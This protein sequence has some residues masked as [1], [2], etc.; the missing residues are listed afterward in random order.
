[1]EK[2]ASTSSLIK[3]VEVKDRKGCGPFSLSPFLPPHVNVYFA[4]AADPWSG[5]MLLRILLNLGFYHA[6]GD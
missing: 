6:K 5:S 4:M 2:G 1:M 3:I